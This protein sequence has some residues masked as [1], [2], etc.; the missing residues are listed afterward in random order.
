MS[1]YKQMIEEKE[2]AIN[3]DQLNVWERKYFPDEYKKKIDKINTA[4]HNS[5]YKLM[6]HKNGLINEEK[7]LRYQDGREDQGS[8]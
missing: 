8:R 7:R 6:L 2:I 1:E 3:N 5:M 4:I